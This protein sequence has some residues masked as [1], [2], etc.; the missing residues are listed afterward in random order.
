MKLIQEKLLLK[1]KFDPNPE[2]PE[3]NLELEHAY[4]FRTH[5]N[6]KMNVR[7]NDEGNLVYNL[8]ALGIIHNPET[9]E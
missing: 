5:N 3:I 4:G 7:F 9:N 2:A 6:A 1:H 8:A